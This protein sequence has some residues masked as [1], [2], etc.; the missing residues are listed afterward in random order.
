MK[1]C[2]AHTDFLT[3]IKDKEDREEYVKGIRKIAGI[4]SCAVFTTNSTMGVKD[5]ENFKLELDY[6]NK[7]YHT[8]LLLSI[9]DLGFIKTI[10]ELYELIELR[11]ISVTLT[12]NDKNQFAGG[13]HTNKGLTDLGIKVVKLLEENN[14]LIDTAHL[15]RKAFKEFCKIT[16]KPIYNSHS[17]INL[18]HKHNRNLTDKQIKKIVDS[19][20]FLGLTIYEKFISNE[21]ITAREIAQQADYLIKKFGYTNFG[22]G[23]DIYGIQKEF[24]PT[25][26]KSYFEIQNLIKEMKKLHYSKKIINAI[27]FKNYK[28]FLKRIKNL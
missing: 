14:I 10:E 19:D 15:S 3:E 8:K 26:L 21:K 6:Y 16:T 7:K 13:A 5:V 28:K 17:N 24:L 11:P 12:W 27:M 25:D 9:E 1:I 22:L 23:T 18:L 4:I 20:G 2:D